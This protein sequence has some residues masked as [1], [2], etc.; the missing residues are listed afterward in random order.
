MLE[1]KPCTVFV[2]KKLDTIFARYRRISVRK[3]IK[4]ARVRTFRWRVWGDQRVNN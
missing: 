3:E 1:W 4:A 2:F